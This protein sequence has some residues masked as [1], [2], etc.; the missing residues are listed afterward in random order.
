MAGQG[1]NSLINAVT[2]FNY[3]FSIIFMFSLQ[4]SGTARGRTH[5]ASR[6]P[7]AALMGME[8]VRRQSQRSRRAQAKIRAD[9]EQNI[10]L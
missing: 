2:S 10:E 4:L 7:L 9:K 3:F 1:E 8:K 5:S 6:A